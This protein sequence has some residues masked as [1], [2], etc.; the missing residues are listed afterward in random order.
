[1]RGPHRHALSA[2]LL[3]G[4]R[5]RLSRDRVDDLL[6]VRGEQ[7]GVESL[8]AHRFRH[9]LAHTW[10]A[11]G[12]QERDLMRLAGWRSPEMLSRHAASTADRR[13]REAHR[14]LAL[15]DHL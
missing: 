3:L 10:L 2:G 6:R 12:G 7:A 11:S 14:R 1:M 8:H 5:G 15:G 13:A 4:Q 9:T